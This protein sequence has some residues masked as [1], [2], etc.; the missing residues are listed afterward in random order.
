M[1]YWAFEQITQVVGGEASRVLAGLQSLSGLE[2]RAAEVAQLQQDWCA[3]CDE[4]VEARR[5]AR[6]NLLDKLLNDVRECSSLH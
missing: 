1:E 4:L 3:A 5:L 6:R 2:E